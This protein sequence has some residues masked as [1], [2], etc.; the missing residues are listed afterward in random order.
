MGGLHQILKQV[1]LLEVIW[2]LNL[3]ILEKRYLDQPL[4]A[5]G[6]IAVLR[7]RDRLAE[8]GEEARVLV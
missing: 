4:L 3:L 5:I 7:V 6:S 1:N 2:R 8:L